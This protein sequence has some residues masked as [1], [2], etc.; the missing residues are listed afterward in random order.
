MAALDDHTLLRQIANGDPEALR[1]LYARYQVRLRGFLWSLLGRNTEHVEDV[2]QETFVAIWRSASSYQGRSQPATWI[3]HLARNVA[4][5]ARRQ[6]GKHQYAVLLDDVEHDPLQWHEA[7][8]E[9]TIV[10]RLT[11]D[12]ALQQI[13]T[14]HREVLELVFIHGFLAEEI[15]EILDV[16]LGTVKSRLSYARRALAS[17]LNQTT[18]QEE[19]LTDA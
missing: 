19:H 17:A 12:E 3:Y 5:H 2:L 10:A 14:K 1:I 11:L 4:A 8:Q 7:S 6:Q 15:A 18:Y 16:P 9:E 13:S